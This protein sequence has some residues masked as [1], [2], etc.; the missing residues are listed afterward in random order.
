MKNYLVDHNLTYMYI[1]ASYG[2]DNRY[3]TNACLVHVLL[4]ILLGEIRLKNVFANNLYA[5]TMHVLLHSMR[6]FMFEV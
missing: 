2:C 6:V 5:C 1:K 4:Y 3:Q